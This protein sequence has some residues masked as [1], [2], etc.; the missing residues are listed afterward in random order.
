MRLGLSGTRRFGRSGTRDSDYRERGIVA[1]PQKCAP[2]HAPSNYANREESF[3]FLLTHLG[4]VRNID[5]GGRGSRPTDQS[6]DLLESVIRTSCFHSGSAG[7]WSAASGT[8]GGAFRATEQRPF[9]WAI[10]ADVAV[11]AKARLAA[12]LSFRSASAPCRLAS[13]DQQ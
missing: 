2:N 11:R 9:G 12:T 4:S 5:A 6:V 10:G 13:G 3:G 1:N 8:V 7:D